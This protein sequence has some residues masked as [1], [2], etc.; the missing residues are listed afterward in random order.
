MG[1]IRAIAA[2]FALATS[3]SGGVRA[4]LTLLRRKATILR[5]QLL[6]ATGPKRRHPLEPSEDPEEPAERFVDD[7]R[8]DPHFWMCMLPH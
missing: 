3:H 2:P 8:T 1:A 4:T 7:Y 6:E 5:A